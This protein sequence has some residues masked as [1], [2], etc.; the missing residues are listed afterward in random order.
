MPV[1]GSAA[2]SSAL[3]PSGRT[4]TYGPSTWKAAYSAIAPVVTAA[5]PTPAA[6]DGGA[7]NPNTSS[8]S[9]KPSTSGPSL[10]TVP[11]KSV[12]GT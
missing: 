11:A 8:P 5:M 7:P 9:A 4:A 3:S 2:A 6:N 1:L 12:P 10:V